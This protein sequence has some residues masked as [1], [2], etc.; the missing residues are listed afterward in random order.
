[1]SRT[2]YECTKCGAT[3]RSVKSYFHCFECKTLHWW[4]A[5]GRHMQPTSNFRTEID[6]CE[7]CVKQG[8]YQ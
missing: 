6:R 7:T 4:C 1:M 3:L 8:R 2:D 5:A